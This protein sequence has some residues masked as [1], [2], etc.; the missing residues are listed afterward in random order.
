MLEMPSI[1][2]GLCNGCGLCVEVCTCHAFALVDNVAVV[3]ETEECG[4]CTDCEM[5]CPTGAIRCGYEVVFIEY[6]EQRQIVIE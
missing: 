4:F 5:V 6:H 1:D 2:A 3:V